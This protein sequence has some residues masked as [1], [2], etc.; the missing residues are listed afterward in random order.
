MKRLGSIAL[1]CGVMTTAGCS[2]LSG[3]SVGCDPVPGDGLAESTDAVAL[4]LW[5]SNQSFDV[6]PVDI[7][8]YVDDQQA[9]CDTFRVESQHTWILYELM[10]DPG[11][12]TIKAVSQDGEA[13]LIEATDIPDE[14]WAL[15]QFWTEEG[16]NFFTFAIQDE[17]IFF[18]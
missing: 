8:V 12:H 9:V 2:G 15:V 13:E 6:D 16:R 17:P 3:S 10:V 7:Q 18:A 14:R 1:A 11:Q 4:H 5:V